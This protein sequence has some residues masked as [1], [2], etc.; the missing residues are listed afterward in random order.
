MSNFPSGEGFFETIQT[1]NRHPVALDFHLARARASADRLGVA[2]PSDE[3]LE[4]LVLETISVGEESEY[5]RLRI[6]FSMLG[7]VE[8]SHESYE[9]WNSPAKVDFVSDVI[10][11]NSATMGIKSLPYT[12]NL[13]M[14]EKA[15]QEGFDEVIRIDSKGHV[16]EGAVSN[17]V[18]R[19]NGQWMTPALTSG[20]LPGIV[21]A[22]CIA[23]LGVLEAVLLK[24][25]IERADAG[26]LLSS[27]KLAQP[28]SHIGDRKL[29]IVRDFAEQVSKC[30]AE[31]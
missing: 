22:V 19:T 5:G 17:V 30:M 14:L 31:L 28:I 18:F 15:K 21:R 2:F 4:R 13:S 6:V 29:E 27:L 10:V 26:F 24:E 23:E 7:K 3:K 20:C 12:V 16:S 8:V 11:H 9:M 1:H 25:D